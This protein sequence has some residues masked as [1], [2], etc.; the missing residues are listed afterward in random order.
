MLNAIRALARAQTFPVWVFICCCRK[1]RIRLLSAA[2]NSKTRMVSGHFALHVTT[3]IPSEAPQPALPGRASRPYCQRFAEQMLAKAS[4]LF[5][6]L[7]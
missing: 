2:T 6:C 4:H 7:S 1:T 3:D 5:I